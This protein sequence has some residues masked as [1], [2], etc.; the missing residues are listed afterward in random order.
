MKKQ[1]NLYETYNNLLE[2]KEEGKKIIGVIPH[3]IVP[4]ELILASNSIPL[5][6]CLG[7]TE[8]QMNSGHA[9]LTQ[10]TCGFQRVNLGIFEERESIS[11]QIYD[12]I[13][14]VISG[15][16]CAGVQNTGMYLERYF[17][18]EQ[19]RLIIPFCNTPNP[20]NYYLEELVQLKRFLENK[21]NVIISNDKLIESIKLYN[22]LRTLY[23]EIDKFR[24]QDHPVISL[25]DIQNLI[26]HLYLNGPRLNLEKVNEFL[27]F[28]KNRGL[29]E[30]TGFRIFL[31]GSGVL[32]E[33]ELISLIENCNCT[34]AGDD[35]FTG[36][37]FYSS[38]VQLNSS[39]P[40]FALAERYLKRNLSGRM[41]PNSYRIKKIIEICKKRKIKGIIN[42]YL[43][44]CDSYA[45]TTDIFKEQMNKEGI[46][47]LNL[48]R[49]YSKNSIGQL[50]TRIEAFL[51]ML[52][53]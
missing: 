18:K 47:V 17:G 19:Y 9:Y 21:N 20:F 12:L 41:M 7:G 10:T 2:F 43:K 49:D 42:N 4:D 35:L 46:L 31:A 26:H 25:S 27:A 3:T 24:Y 48:E 6:F 5:H 22:K 15:T 32:F 29:P 14:V 28:L 52:E 45:N 13:D 23:Q 36:F 53:E 50:K 51:E 38:Q 30:K 33:D 16:F 1:T 34:I 39:D 37:E 40:P 44:F 11:Y 8:D